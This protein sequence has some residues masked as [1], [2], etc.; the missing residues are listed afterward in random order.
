[1]FYGPRVGETSNIIKSMMYI[2]TQTNLLQIATYQY[3]FKAP[4][5]I[6][7]LPLYTTLR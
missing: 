2:F 1:M 5:T 3:T 6:G 4:F 7:A